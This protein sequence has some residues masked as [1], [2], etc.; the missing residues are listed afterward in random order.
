M[1]A[2]ARVT[3]ADRRLELIVEWEPSPGVTDPLLAATWCRL[4]IRL[5]GRGVTTVEDSRSRALR[6]A[7]Y[8]SAYPLAEWVAERWWLLQH[9]MRPSA[10][11]HRDWSWAEVQR[12]PWLRSH[13]L[14][15]AGGGMPWPDLTLVP[16]GAGARVQWRA[17]AG[18]A[19]SP[20]TFL[21]SGEDYLPAAAVV[22]PLER[23]VDQVLQRLREHRLTGSALEREWALVSESD[24]DEMAFA[25]AVARLGLDPYDVDDELADDVVALADD[26]DPQLLTEFLDSVRPDG[27]RAAARWLQQS[28]DVVTPLTRPSLLDLGTPVPDGGPMQADGPWGRG[29]AL[30]RAYRKQLGLGPRELFPCEEYVGSATLD[31]PAAGLQ[32]AVCVDGDQ[33]GLVLPA[34]IPFSAASRR[35]AQGRALGLSLL[36]DRRLMLLDPA[37]T[38]LTKAARA[39]AAELLAP[40]EG[41]GEYLSA[42]PDVTSSAFEAVAARYDTSPLLVQH[43]YD[44]QIIR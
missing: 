19:D 39:F 33:L 26:L 34:E 24:S 6:R 27:L 3:A 16:E 4:E 15:A 44:N 25:G 20:L 31:A 7:V 17:G 11:P 9:H 32:G 41:I 22:D 5:G 12:Q 29:Y 23:F 40:A 14:R 38:E 1:A 18:L 10:V 2:V 43:Q 37:H 8:T 21:T 13:N 28:R 35:F 36:T 42:L 30:A